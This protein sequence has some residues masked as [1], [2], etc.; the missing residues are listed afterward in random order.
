MKYGTPVMDPV[1]SG[2]GGLN[3]SGEFARHKPLVPW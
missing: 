2:N 1:M 3:L